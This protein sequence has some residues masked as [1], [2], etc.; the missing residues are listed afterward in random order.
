MKKNIFFAIS[1]FS[2]FAA[3]LFAEVTVVNPVPGNFANAQTLVIKA[4]DGEDIY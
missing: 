3:A 4:N 1:F 2:F